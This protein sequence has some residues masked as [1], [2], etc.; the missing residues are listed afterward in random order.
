MLETE[1]KKLRE[2]VEANTKAMEAF[3][4]HTARSVAVSED[5]PETD[6]EPTPE[7]K[8]KKA[9]AKP[10]DEPTKETE[11]ETVDLGEL[12]TI[13]LGLS[14]NGKKNEVRAK[15]DSYGAAKI[16][17]L[18]NADAIEFKAWVEEQL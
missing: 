10:K 11:T 13:T 9:K 15:L 17:D 12:K 1:I 8:P 14:R 4:A 16:A 2:A 7:P 5:T 6:P 18:N 3:L